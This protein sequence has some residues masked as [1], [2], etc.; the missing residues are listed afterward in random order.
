MIEAATIRL[1]GWQEADLPVLAEMR[2]DTALQAQLLARA[3]GSNAA[4]VRQWLLDRSTDAHGLLLVI[5]SRDDDTALGYLQFSEMGNADRRAE[6]GICLHAR[7]QGRGAG[8]DALGAVMPYLRDVWAVRK[9][10]LRVRADNPR[11]IA[12]Y[13]RVGFERCGLWREHVFIDGGFRDVVLMEL[14]L[15]GKDPACAS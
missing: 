15:E 9:V 11:A 1:R 10:S 2:N 12:C 13:A 6:L 7:A 4:Q 3:R 14:F 8:R 5:A